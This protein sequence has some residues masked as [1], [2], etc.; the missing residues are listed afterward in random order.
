MKAVSLIPPLRSPSMERS[1]R[2]A[3]FIQSFL[4]TDIVNHC[5]ILKFIQT[6]EKE[7]DL[8]LVHLFER[9]GLDILSKGG[10]TL[11]KD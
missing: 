10:E 1:T 3:Q 9:L 2:M 5:E 8:L 11:Q 4:F 6:L 7:D